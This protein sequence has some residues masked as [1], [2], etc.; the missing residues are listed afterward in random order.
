MNVA[1]ISESTHY[2]YTSSYVN[3]AIIQKWKEHQ[4]ELLYSLS[5]QEN[6]LVL[7][8]D[9][10][11][12]SPGY[13]AKFGSFR[14]LEQQINRVVDFEL[15]QVSHLLQDLV[16]MFTQNQSYIMPNLTH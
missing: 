3:P 10:R 12:D 4:Q 15:V 7:A 14:L 6:G 13:S 2:R 8:G 16:I 5:S 1:C 11:C 9:G